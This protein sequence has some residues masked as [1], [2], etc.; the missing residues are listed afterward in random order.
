MWRSVCVFLRA[1]LWRYLVY[2]FS[3]VYGRYDNDLERMERVIPLF[4]KKIRNHEPITIYGS[5]KVLDFTYVD[6]VQI[7]LVPLE[8]D[9]IINLVS[10][11]G[12]SLTTHSRTVSSI[13][14]AGALILRSGKLQGEALLYKPK[15]KHSQ[16]SRFTLQ[17]AVKRHLSSQ[18]TGT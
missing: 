1:I 10:A 6:V 4:I 12:R 9:D 14:G 5:D 2:R 7:A 17:Y 8:R 13:S 3:N 16:S 11:H 18:E 15:Q